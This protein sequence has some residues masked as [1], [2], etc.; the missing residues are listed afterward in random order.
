[1]SVTV[2]GQTSE[3]QF[4]RAN[5]TW[6]EI[7][8]IAFDLFQWPSKLDENWF[9]PGGPGVDAAVAGKLALD[10]HQGL[11]DGRIIS[12]ITIKEA[13]LRQLPLKECET[14][15]GTGVRNDAVGQKFGMVERVIGPQT[16][17]PTSHPRYG[18]VGWC[19]G[20]DGEGYRRPPRYPV[21]M[22]DVVEFSEFLQVC[23]GFTVG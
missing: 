8:Q 5:L 14:C 1:V 4:H 10:F 9:M 15:S 7:A 16:Q 6:F 3:A 13:E 17:S 22:A 11:Q 20:C 18:Q 21:V 2:C 19:N 23:G 12:Y